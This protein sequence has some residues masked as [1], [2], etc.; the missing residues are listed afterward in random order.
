MP[1][2]IGLGLADFPFSSSPAFWRWIALCEE[3]GVDS[4]WQTDRLTGPQPYLDCMSLMAA[5][6]G[7]TRRM[8]F[9]MNVLA[10]GLREPVGVAKACATIDF[11]SEGRLL[12]AFGI[13]SLRSPDWAAT[14]ISKAGQGAR[15]DEALEIMIRLWAGETVDFDGAH[16][17]CREAR[18]APLPRQQPLP[19]WLGGSSP[20]AIRRTGRFATGWQAGA[21]AGPELARLV[22]EIRLA[23][24]AAGREIDPEHFS[25]SFFFRFGGPD[26]VVVEARRAA[27][28]RQ[29]PD[30]DPDQ[31][32]V[33]G[34]A[35]LII[36]RVA[37]LRACGV[38]KFILRPL[39]QGDEDLYAQTRRLL[40][41]VIPVV[42][43]KA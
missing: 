21:E 20:A 9:G 15:A 39:G 8:K 3:G 4:L 41:E 5:L 32:I 10:L 17:T 11:L 36:Q 27:Y 19:I 25:A 14:G 43:G 30:R 35:S 2:R 1:V 42:H 12:P 37:D 34:D 26:E 7:A 24:A 31:L 33:A 18:I 28:R 16:F 40:E 38:T 23:A 13:G 29:F 6:A 22:A